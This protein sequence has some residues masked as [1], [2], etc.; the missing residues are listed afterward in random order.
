M[1]GRGG[2]VWTEVAASILLDTARNHH[3]GI[4]ISET[5]FDVRVA[6]IILEAHVVARPVLFDK[7]GLKNERLQL[8]V[9]D[10]EVQIGYFGNYGPGLGVLLRRGM[11]IR[12]HAVA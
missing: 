5:Y 8:R 9:R 11:E 1:Y 2:G 6:L 3:L 7:V 10:D 4:G 12:A